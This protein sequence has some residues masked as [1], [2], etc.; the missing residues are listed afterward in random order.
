MAM[1]TFEFEK[2]IVDLEARL[3]ELRQ[4]EAAGEDVA[5]ELHVA[6]IELQKTRETIYRNLTPHQR[7]LIARHFDRPHSLD[8]IRALFEQFTELHGDRQFRDDPSVVCGFGFFQGRPMA[9]IGQQKGKDVKE[10]VARNFGM[11]HPE[12]YRKALRVM[13]LADKFRRP[14]AIF[15]DTPGAYPGIGAEERGQAEAIARNI[16]EMFTLSV[17]IVVI[18]IGEGASGG[19][20]GIGVGDR[21]LMLENAWYSVISPEGCA[22]ILW[23]DAKMAPVAAANLKLTAPDLLQLGIIDDIIAE[24]LG[25]AHRDPLVAIENVRVALEQ[26]LGELIPLAPDML[27]RLRH[28][29]YRAMGKFIEEVSE[30]AEEAAGDA[31][32]A[33]TFRPPRSR[34][35]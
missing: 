20:L 11:M 9:V 27:R 8:Y 33:Q 23:R 25:G 1:T 5:S 29:K 7:V 17:P 4:R 22:S 18:I 14:I 28:E 3:A 6:E 26:A 21:V 31:T 24:P 10:N 34:K 16:M 32:P 13:K 19:A 2:P 30:T 15:V 12:G 35:L